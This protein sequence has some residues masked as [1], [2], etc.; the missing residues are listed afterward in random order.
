[1]LTGAF[2]DPRST[3]EPIVA[4]ND[5]VS[6]FTQVSGAHHGEFKGIPATSRPFLV[7]NADICRFTDGGLICEHRELIDT[8]SLMRQPGIA[9]PGGGQVILAAAA[10]A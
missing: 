9:G 6:A 10:T 4:D 5:L 8:A 2:N 1:M 3:T 7:N